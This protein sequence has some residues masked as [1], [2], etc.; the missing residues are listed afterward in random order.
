[1]NPRTCEHPEELAFL[2]GSD[3]VAAL[4]PG[5]RALEDG[6]RRWVVALGLLLHRLGRL[7]IS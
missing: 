3:R 4:N 5:P 7:R 2:L 1:M 6:G